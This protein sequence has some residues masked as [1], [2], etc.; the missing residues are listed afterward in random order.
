M[1]ILFHKKIQKADKQ[2]TIARM[3]CGL[4]KICGGDVDRNKDKNTE[5]KHQMIFWKQRIRK[6]RLKVTWLGCEFQFT[7]CRLQLRS[8]SWRYRALC[9][10][11]SCVPCAA[12]GWCLSLWQDPV[13]TD[14]AV[15]QISLPDRA[16]H[17]PER[18]LWSVHHQSVS[19][20]RNRRQDQL[21]FWT[22]WPK[23]CS[24]LSLRLSACPDV[25]HQWPS[26]CERADDWSWTFAL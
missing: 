11:D 19:S 17:K 1:N 13:C 26:V 18:I 12:C 7:F 21:W 10:Y 9:S 6:K 24:E 25:K 5:S 16:Y 8:W 14:D 2:I 15:V 23:L 4:Y 3:I 20:Y 22:C